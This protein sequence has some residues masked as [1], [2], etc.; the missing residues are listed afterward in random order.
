[1]T[2]LR[3]S[4]LAG[5]LAVP[6][7]VVLTV[8]AMMF[9]AAPML[10]A[11]DDATGSFLTPFP[12]GDV[13]QVS[14]LGDGFATGLLE[15]LVEAIGQDTRLS[16]Q[17]RVRD[18]PTIMSADFDSKV[19]DLERELATEPLNIAVVMVGESDRVALRSSTG[20]RVPSGSPEWLVEYGRRVDLLMKVIKRKNP[21]V[22]WVGLP[23]LA[24]GDANEQ[25]Q[26]MNDVLRER[27]YLNSFK[28]IDAYAGFSDEANGY[29]AYGPDLQG[30]I[31][32]LRQGDG[33][34]FT[35]AGNRKLAHFVE[36]ELRRDLNQARANRTIPLL[37]SEEEQVKVNPDNAV[38]TPAPSS[39]AAITA[40]A[41]SPP[42]VKA[43]P[44]D[45][46]AP[47][48][49]TNAT[50]DQKADNSRITLNVI[51]ASG[52]EE[53]QTLDIV[54]PA[55]P[56]SVVALMA[57]REGSGQIGDLMVDQISG[58]LTLMSSITPSGN[59][60]RGKLSPTQAP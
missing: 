18:V 15:G 9:A 12:D 20:R 51:G 21:G 32:V 59:R 11:D 22:Y 44:T 19:A 4:T 56:A 57:R 46:S 5:L 40:A 30:K 49:T 29:S 8:L 54:R 25:A 28:Y 33:V 58:G 13:Y 45:G 41:S 26:K 36:K 7:A 55:I 42:T 53:K 14:V 43:A 47:G 34:S 27:A 50:G 31:R 23:I 24:R 16:I 2:S 6:V 60:S 35:G 1:M 52:R 17:R 10:A 39:P 38:K 37:G 48:S 3:Q